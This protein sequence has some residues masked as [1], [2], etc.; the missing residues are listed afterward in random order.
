MSLIMAISVQRLRY[1]HRLRRHTHEYAGHS[2]AAVLAKLLDKDKGDLVYWYETFAEEYVTSKKCWKRKK[3]YSD[4]PENLNL[5]EYK[6]LLFK[7]LKDNLEI[8]GFNMNDLKQQELSKL[9]ATIPISQEVGIS[10]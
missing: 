8:T 9:T 2:R 1:T 10:K 3:S 7:K 4:K 6:N 5:E